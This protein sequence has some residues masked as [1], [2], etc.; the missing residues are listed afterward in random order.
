MANDWRQLERGQTARLCI[1]DI[2][3]GQ[4]QVV[5]ESNDGVIEAPNWSPDGS[6]LIYNK[7]GLIY[8]LPWDGSGKPALL[9]T[10]DVSDANNDHVLSPD[11]TFVY[12]TSQNGHLYE[13][14]VQGG[15]PRRVSNEHGHPF[16]YFLHGISPDGKM[17]AYTGAEEVNGN[18]FGSLNIFTIPVAGGDDIQLTRS[19]KPNDG[20]EYSPDGDW[21]YFNSEMA[22]SVPG[23]AQLFKMRAD[24]SE[25][26]QLT[27]DD[28][29]N[30]FP[31][32]SPDG[33]MV[34]YMS[35]ELGTRGHP[36]NK[37]VELLCMPPEGG[38]SEQLLRLFGGQGTINV[39]SWAPDSR[40]FA[41]VEYPVS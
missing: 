36:A 20:P 14:P 30:W 38:K 37:T 33:K 6:W 39:N 1:F 19:D 7:D 15:T 9:D 3:S 22:S 21:I 24:G 40:R 23:H 31:H 10:G 34:V 5:Y 13:V 35:Y 18:A 25:V 11:G 12:L 27:H 26:T 32:V 4:K 29:V 28:K 41:F 16:R 8:R 2:A 17:L